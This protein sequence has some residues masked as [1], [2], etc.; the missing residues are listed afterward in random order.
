MQFHAKR[1]LE[2]IRK[3]NWKKADA[4]VAEAEKTLPKE[5]IN[6]LRSAIVLAERDYVAGCGVAENLCRGSN[7][8]AELQAAGAFNNHAWSMATDNRTSQVGLAEGEALARCAD[9]VCKGQ[10]P[11]VLDT[12]ARLLFRQEKKAQAVELEEKAV[13]LLPGI[14]D[15]SNQAVSIHVA[16]GRLRARFEA[17]LESY[18]RGELPRAN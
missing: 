13:K 2:A 18:R 9:E 4:G 5:D 12:L 3:K 8:S 14:I 1:V 16:S 11:M 17:T 7:G 10:N 15:P 6:W